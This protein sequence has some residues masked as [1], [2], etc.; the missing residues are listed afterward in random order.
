[1]DDFDDAPTTSGAAGADE[2]LSLPKGISF[3]K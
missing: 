1:M 3:V 2:E